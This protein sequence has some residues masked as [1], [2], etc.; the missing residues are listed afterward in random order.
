M[1]MCRG[2]GGGSVMFLPGGKA[3]KSSAT[4]SPWDALSS[5]PKQTPAEQS[6]T[7]WEQH[8][9]WATHE[10]KARVMGTC[11]GFNHI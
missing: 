1:Q 8:L 10:L 6:R 5:H 2:K 4:A 7:F 3:G 11:G 9:C